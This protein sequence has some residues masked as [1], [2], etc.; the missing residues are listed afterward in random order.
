MTQSKITIPNTKQQA[1]QGVLQS[2]NHHGLV[3][4]SQIPKSVLANPVAQ[5][6]SID[7]D[8]C[9]N[10]VNL[11][12]ADSAETRL[13]L[14]LAVEEE[15][16]G[17]YGIC[18][19]RQ[20]TFQRFSSIEL[21]QAE[22]SARLMQSIV[23]I[24]NPPQKKIGN[25]IVSGGELSTDIVSYEPGKDG[26]AQQRAR[27]VSTGLKMAYSNRITEVKTPHNFKKNEIK[28]VFVP[29]QLVDMAREFFTDLKI[30][31]V[32]SKVVTLHA[33][34]KILELYHN[35]IL[36]KPLK[37]EAPDYLGAI[38]TFCENEHLTTFSLH[39]VRL[40]TDFDFIVRPISRVTGNE[41]IIHSTYAKIAKQFDDDSAFIIVHK[42]YGQSKL[43]LIERLRVHKF[44]PEDC[45]VKMERGCQFSIAMNTNLTQLKGGLIIS[46]AYKD[47]SEVQLS[48]LVDPDIKVIK[49]ERFYVLA[50]PLRL[51]EYVNTVVNKFHVMQESVT[52]IQAFTRGSRTRTFFED[53]RQ[54]QENL[55][56]AQQEFKLAGEQLKNLTS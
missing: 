43:N 45:I 46:N 10:Y 26:F 14:S 28:A 38:H 41:H 25:C 16:C 36:K 32:I 23:F 34:P 2:I 47:L 33:I 50:Y 27:S 19:E 21:L 39:A 12:K 48:L 30:I 51:E 52:K 20:W 13:A 49:A 4:L 24:L 1:I 7:G 31:P 37:V 8:I 3:P 42:N 11:R 54:K 6:Q 53:Y 22:A 5:V 17:I 9:V 55:K 29:E 15:W 35:E 44:L 56:I 18:L 40:H